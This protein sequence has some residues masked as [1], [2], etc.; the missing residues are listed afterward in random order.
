MTSIFTTYVF[1]RYIGAV[2][3]TICL[4]YVRREQMYLAKNVQ[5][6]V[7]R[8]LSDGRVA[9]KH[10][11]GLLRRDKAFEWILTSAS[12]PKTVIRWY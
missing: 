5:I 8:G 6:K 3:V 1:D 4:L 12:K 10:N 2:G 7:N 9:K 11:P